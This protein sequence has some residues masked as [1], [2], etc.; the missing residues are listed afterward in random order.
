VKFLNFLTRTFNIE[1][2]KKARVAIR[3]FPITEKVLFF[4]AVMVFIIS[5]V[6]LFF[7]VNAS[8]LVEVPTH[9]GTLQEGIIGT[10][11]FINP[12]LAISDAD[13]DLTKLVYAG[14]TKASPEGGYVPDLAK[15]YTIS[16]DGT[17]YTFILK[18]ELIFQDGDP[19]TTEDVAFTISMAQ[20]AI[21]K[22]PKRVNW[23]GVS[24]NIISPTEIQFILSEGFEPF[25]ENTTL[26]ILPKHIWNNI[27]ADQF[28]FSQFNVEP[29]GAGP[30]Q[31]KTVRY[32]SGGLPEHYELS[33]FKNYALGRP[34][35]DRIIVRLYQ[36]SD[37]LIEAF[38]KGT[39]DSLSGFTKEEYQEIS[40]DRA[41]NL[42]KLPLPR[43]FGVFFN[44]NEDPALLNK[45]VR[46]ALS[47][48]VGRQE[49][50]SEV[51]GEF[52]EATGSPIPNSGKTVEPASAQQARELLEKK[53]WTVNEETGIYEKK[54]KEGVEK[55]TFSISTSN[56]PELVQTAELLKSGW[57]KI[58]AEVNVKIFETN[59]LNQ[60][61]IRPRDY[62]SLLFGLVLGRNTDLY[63]FW[64]S[65]GRTDPGLNVAQYTNITVDK[66]LEDVR[67]TFDKTQRQELFDSFTEELQNDIPAVFVYSPYFTYILPDNVKHAPIGNIV[68][69]A[70]R[71]NNINEWYVETDKVWKIFVN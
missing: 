42:V 20:D 51:F 68:L 54:N 4:G 18:D 3:N 19:L 63:P 23:E 38:K 47:I 2:F 70:D 33:P 52:A 44:Q 11:R 59:D 21:L 67:V 5:A 64:H 16:E 65:S 62:D 53:G 32:S 35:I 7:N 14:L 57:Q 40:A 58:G 17:I 69:P 46:Q 43:I 60:N 8:L 50:V 28:Q 12:V 66:I 45:E 71:F 9:G 24:V 13:R 37:K 56:T 26:G 61:V 15:S 29:V 6:V 27:T 48:S 22:S 25:I 1:I 36:N 10:P 30:Y 49:I 55:L 39:V 31:I 34:Y 41:V